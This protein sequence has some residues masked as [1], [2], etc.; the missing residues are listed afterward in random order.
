MCISLALT[1]GDKGGRVSVLGGG[2][3][4]AKH[5]EGLFFSK[6]RFL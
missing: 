2:W 1:A 3:E 6:W 5:P 4:Q